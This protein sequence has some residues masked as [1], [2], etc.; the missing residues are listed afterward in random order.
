M[1]ILALDL[2]TSTGWAC[3]TLE[4]TPI[5][6]GVLRLPKTG[7]DLG[8]FGEA[9]E[10]WLGPAIE[11]MA[12]TEIIYE[13]PIM[14]KLT[15]MTTL[16]KLGGLCFVTEIIAR[17]YKVLVREANLVH[18]RKHFIGTTQAP[19]A[20]T[21]PEL[22]RRWLKDRTI[23]ECRQRGFHVAGDDDAD[24]VAL[25]SFALSLYRPDFVLRQ[26]RPERAA[27]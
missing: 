15:S 17:R 7:E 24:A 9:F 25:L 13:S 4:G 14:P 22:R 21:T 26:V 23:A 16:R 19:R 20:I 8:R 18:I 11:D 27:A 3:G 12:P 5:A 6:H 10:N 2:A 1:R